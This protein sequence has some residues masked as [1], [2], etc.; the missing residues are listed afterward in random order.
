MALPNAQHFVIVIIQQLPRLFAMRWIIAE[1]V[2]AML[3]TPFEHQAKRDGRGELHVF[4]VAA[5]HSP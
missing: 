4:A 2:N 1:Y 5:P 3:C